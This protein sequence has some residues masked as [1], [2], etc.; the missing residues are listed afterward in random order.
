[1]KRALLLVLLAGVLA[2]CG[3]SKKNEQ[4]TPPPVVLSQAQTKDEWARRIVNRLMRPLNKDLQ[5]VNGLSNP[6]IILFIINQNKTTLTILNQRLGD[7]A[8]CSSKLVSIGPPPLGSGPLQRAN[9]KFQAACRDYVQLAQMLQKASLFLS[10]GRNDVIL[11]GRKLLRSAIP[12]ANA[13][14]STYCTAIKIVQKQPEFRRAGLRPS[15]C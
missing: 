4:P 8:Q 1:M 3:S 10:S 2:G 11:E 12:T 7:L 9:T 13:A 14:G 15:S 6:T 5:V